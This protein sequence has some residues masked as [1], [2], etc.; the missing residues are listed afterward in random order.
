MPMKALYMFPLLFIM[1]IAGCNK[2]EEQN[3]IPLV[4]TSNGGYVTSTHFYNADGRI[5][6]IED[7]GVTSMTAT[8]GNSNA[9]LVYN[10]SAQVVYELNSAGHAITESGNGQT[11]R[12][13]YNTAGNNTHVII[14]NDTIFNTWQNDNMIK[15]SFSNSA[16]VYDYTY[17][18]SGT[19]TIKNANSG[20]AFLHVDSKDLIKT[21]RCNSGCADKDYTYEFDSEGRV[22]KQ[23]IT[24]I[25]GGQQQNITYTYY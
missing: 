18:T 4:K 25:Q 5:E 7:D 20:M 11:I 6:H 16:V 15:T 21:K 1:L 14:G 10:G 17:Y 23:T 13:V 19:N 8:Y 24:S 12:Y 3:L 9:T 22:S 2:D